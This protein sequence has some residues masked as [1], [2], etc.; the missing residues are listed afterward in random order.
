MDSRRGWSVHIR[1]HGRGPKE[2]WRWD[3]QNQR[4]DDLAT[5]PNLPFNAGI[6]RQSHRSSWW[7]NEGKDK[8][9]GAV[10]DVHCFIFSRT[11]RKA[12]LQ[13]LKNVYGAVSTVEKKQPPAPVAVPIACFERNWSV[14]ADACDCQKGKMQLF[15]PNFGASKHLL[16]VLQFRDVASCHRPPCRPSCTTVGL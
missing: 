14:T 15:S 3:E 4:M 1:E 12:W 13:C 9:K 2:P 16:L 6:P 7:G 10:V 11:I 8:S 5:L